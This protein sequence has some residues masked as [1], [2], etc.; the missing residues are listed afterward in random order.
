M[1]YA[2]DQ[3]LTGFFSDLVD[4][5]NIHHTIYQYFI[6]VL[7]PVIASS[8]LIL[9]TQDKDTS[10]EPFILWVFLASKYL[11]Y[12]SHLTMYIVSTLYR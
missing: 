5:E 10:Q 4:K 6:A 11:L 8:L 2:Y 12:M 3:I 1:H 9:S 7:S